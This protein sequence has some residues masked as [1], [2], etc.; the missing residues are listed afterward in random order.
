MECPS[1]ADLLAF[2]DGT[3]SAEARRDTERHLDGC[4]A[5]LSVVAA[6]ARTSSSGDPAAQG[7]PGRATVEG[8]L[9]ADGAPRYVPGAEIARGGMGRILAAEDRLLGRRV[10]LKTLRRDSEGLARRFRREQRITAR[11]QHPA[12]VPIYDAGTFAGGEP[13]FAMR[14]VKGESLDRT[15]AQAATLEARLRLLPAVI[16]VVDAVAYAHGEGVV[17][18]DLKPQNVLVGPFGEVV[19][20]DWGLARETGAEAE[21]AEKAITDTAAVEAGEPE[22]T[23]AGDVVGT[24]AYMAPEQARGRSADERS[25]VYG[26][27]A[28]L[29]HV[30]AGAPPHAERTASSAGEGALDRPAPLAERIADLPADLATI[31]ERAMAEDPAA[32]Y[33]SARELAED[34]KRWQAG[35]LVAAHR[36]STAERL[37]RFVRR[38]RAPLL[39]AATSLI[40]LVTLG[41]LALRRIVDERASAL[42]ARARAEEA[43]GRAEAQRGAAEQLVGFI[44]GDLRARLERVGRLDALEGV[45]R[46]VI[47]YHDG[48]PPSE[49]AATSLRRAEVAGLAGDVAFASGDLVAAEDSYQRDRRAAE[50]AGSIEGAAEARCTAQIR[51]GDV[52]KRRG[53]LGE[54]TAL[55]EACASLARSGAGPRSRQLDLK[56]RIA[57]A[58]VARIRGD[59]PGARRLLEDGRPIAAALV[60]AQG[61][62]GSEAAELELQLL[63]DLWKTL[64]LSSE[65]PAERAVAADALAL[66]HLRVDA[67]PD[68]MAARY[69]LAV[70]ENAMGAAEEHGG[71]RKAAEESYRRA[72][73]AHQLLASRD[74]SNTEWQRSIGVVADRLGSLMMAR[75][76]AKAALPWLEES[77]AASTR[78]LAIAPGNLE[79]QRDA[80]VSATALGDVLAELDRVGEARAALT[81]AVEI[82]ERIADKAPDAGRSEHDLGVALGHLGQ[83]ELN[84]GRSEA[85][86]AAMERSAA[87]LRRHL[88]AVDTP[89]TRMEL[90][91]AL[92]IMAETERGPAARAHVDEALRVLAPARKL[93]PSHPELQAI[94]ENADKLDRATPR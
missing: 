1:D 59:L 67:R 19:V 75:G 47:A 6:L 46:A 70:A 17:H 84:A 7:E 33:P 32:R 63:G 51:L 16:G 81:K 93:A 14:L 4:P 60:A 43:R 25:D 37:R 48:S 42:D 20:V 90:G 35:R 52:R 69:D 72:L 3:S 15:A 82:L 54:A 18:R 36:Y 29:Y 5:C 45:A 24:L 57:L 28:I 39:V 88:A 23:R 83:L 62:P 12:I 2:V 13:F 66:A 89:Q 10:A 87:I 44:L 61:G 68:D 73:A 65:V 58:E 8:P 76:D 50:E 26:L 64:N 41:G 86:Q 71:D 80:G 53:E 94:I 49:D 22:A 91:G 31:V 85:G 34:L 40:L 21:T 27:G 78:L 9:L 11:L 30:L 77:D 55:Y 79:W 56:S 92:L 38:Y 74:P